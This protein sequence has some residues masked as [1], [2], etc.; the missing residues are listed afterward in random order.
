[1]PSTKKMDFKYHADFGHIEFNSSG[2]MTKELKA[3]FIEWLS[4]YF[5]SKKPKLLLL[6]NHISN[7]FSEVIAVAEKNNLHIIPIQPYSHD[8][9]P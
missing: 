7:Y 5:D 6:D 8:P 9:A 1:F 4:S 2:Y 3:R